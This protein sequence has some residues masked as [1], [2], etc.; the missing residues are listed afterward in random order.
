MQDVFQRAVHDLQSKDGS[1]PASEAERLAALV[2]AIPL[3]DQMLD[4]IIEQTQRTSAKAHMAAHQPW[5]SLSLLHQP[6]LLLIPNQRRHSAVVRPLQGNHPRRDGRLN[7]L[8]C[9]AD[10]S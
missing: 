3:T 1:V 6:L 5:I 7:T 8:G 2:F 9:T 10:P 4:I